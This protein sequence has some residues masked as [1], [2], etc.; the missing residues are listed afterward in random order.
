M[1]AK[2]N[3]EYQNL[4][5]GNKNIIVGKCYEF[6]GRYEIID[7][8]GYYYYYEKSLRVGNKYHINYNVVTDIPSG[9]NIKTIVDVVKCIAYTEDFTF[10]KITKKENHVTFKATSGQCFI[11]VNSGEWMPKLTNIT[12]NIT[13]FGTEGYDFLVIKSINYEFERNDSIIYANVFNR[14]PYRN[15]YLYDD[16]FFSKKLIITNRS[17]DITYYNL[18]YISDNK[19]CKNIISIVEAPYYIDTII[20]IAIRDS[21]DPNYILITDTNNTNYATFNSSMLSNILNKKCKILLYNSHYLTFADDITYPLIKCFSLITE[22][23]DCSKQ[24]SKNND[25]SEDDCSEQNSKNNDCS[26]DGCSEQNIKNNDCSEDDYSKQI[27]K[28][29]DS[30][31]DNCSEQNSKNNDSSEDNCSEQNSKNN[32]SSVDDC[33]EQNSKNNESSEDD[34]SEQNSKNNDSSV[35]DCSEQNSKNNESSE[36]DYS[37]QNSKNNESSEDDYS[38]QNSKNDIIKLTTVYQCD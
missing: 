25:C 21:T 3:N 31:E 9:N 33:S 4:Q 37:E 23:N 17:Y 29:N 12:Y 7:I 36:D 22:N 16:T 35:D 38:E 34:Y 26:E 24:I 27:S 2:Q 28:N 8:F 18:R 11:Y 20:P 10:N 32:D 15:G 19:I 13:Y 6:N 30:S 5:T 1:G 14:K